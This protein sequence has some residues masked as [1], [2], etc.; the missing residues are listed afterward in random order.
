M[1]DVIRNDLGQSEN[2]DTVNE[3]EYILPHGRVLVEV[4]DNGK[5]Y[6]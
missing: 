5:G 1:N 3:V 4:S 6:V 2:E